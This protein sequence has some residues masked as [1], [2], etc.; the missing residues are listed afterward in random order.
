MKDPTGAM[1]IQPPEKSLLQNQRRSKTSQSNSQLIGGLELQSGVQDRQEIG[2][3]KNPYVE[4]SENHGSV[5]NQLTGALKHEE[6]KDAVVSAHA[7]A[8]PRKDVAPRVT[9]QQA[10][11]RGGAPG[12]KRTAGSFP[13][14]IVAG[15]VPLLGW[16]TCREDPACFGAFS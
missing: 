7:H 5:C 11:R 9:E 10:V 14:R 15:A 4:A 13:G 1:V 6:G 3:D 8:G 2:E 12:K 16:H